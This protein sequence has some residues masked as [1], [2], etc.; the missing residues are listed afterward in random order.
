MQQQ[1]RDATQTTVA[2]ILMNLN[3]NDVDTTE[4]RK[5]IA[6]ESRK[7]MKAININNFWGVRQI[8]SPSIGPPRTPEMFDVKPLGCPKIINVRDVVHL[9]E[10]PLTLKPWTPTPEAAQEN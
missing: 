6:H 3:S 4:G 8:T 7:R 1:A 5:A 9:E 2:P 10:D